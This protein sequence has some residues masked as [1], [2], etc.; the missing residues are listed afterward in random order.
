MGMDG[1][2]NTVRNFDI[3]LGD[4][5]FVQS[6][7]FVNIPNGGALNHVTDGEPLNSLVLCNASRAV[8]ATN[9]LDVTPTLLVAPV[10][11]PFLGHI[12]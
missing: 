4:G 5:V 2:R 3:Q 1:A 11:P 9:E 8:R 7:G 6:R 12:G 10:I